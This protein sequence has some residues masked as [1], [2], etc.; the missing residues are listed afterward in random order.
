MKIYMIS[1][2]N[3]WAQ[4]D[5][6][7]TH[8]QLAGVYKVHCLVSV[9]DTQFLP[10]DRLAGPDHEGVLYIGAASVLSSRA[11]EVKKAVSAAFGV[12]PYKNP[13]GHPAGGHFAKFR[14]LREKFP[15]LKICLTLQPISETETEQFGHFRAENEA[16]NK[17]A[18][19][20]GELPPFNLR[21]AGRGSSLSDLVE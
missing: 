12:A 7:H 10:I 9:E 13:Y 8:K 15:F 11:A 3:M 21:P 2:P 14:I 6:D 18:S 16:L 17:Y 19:R 5:T 4:I 20:F 1:D